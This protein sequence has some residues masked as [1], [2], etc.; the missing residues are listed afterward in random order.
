MT[1]EVKGHVYKLVDKY[2]KCMC[3]K[4]RRI[5]MN[6]SW[7]RHFKSYDFILNDFIDKFFGHQ[8]NSEVKGH[9]NKVMDKSLKY[10]YKNFRKNIMNYSWYRSFKSYDFILNDFIYKYFRKGHTLNNFFWTF[11]DLWCQRSFLENCGQ[12]CEIHVQQ[13][14]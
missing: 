10:L 4:F 6:I 1:P 8:M 5:I 12:F 11:N 14:S 7:S 9:L 2:V 13:F 3:K